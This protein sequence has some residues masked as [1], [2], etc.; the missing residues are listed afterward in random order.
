MPV[1]HEHIHKSVGQKIYTS[2]KAEF[3]IT[4]NGHSHKI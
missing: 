4:V 2:C 1:T 3:Q